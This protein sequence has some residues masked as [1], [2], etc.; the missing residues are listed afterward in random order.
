MTKELI[1]DLLQHGVFSCLCMLMDTL[2]MKQS[3]FFLVLRFVLVSVY[4][5]LPKRVKFDPSLFP[6][7]LQKSGK[8]LC[9]I[10]AVCI[11]KNS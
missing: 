5:L 9:L 8:C 3:V 1:E 10:L 11:D 4:R 2:M 7:L 6:V